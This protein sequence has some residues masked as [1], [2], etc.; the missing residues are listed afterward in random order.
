MSQTLFTE[1]KYYD[2]LSAELK[3]AKNDQQLFD[4]IV[5]LPF[6]DKKTSTMLGLGVV[7]LLLVNMKDRTIDRIALSD[8]EQAQGAVNYSVKNFKDIRI[9]LDNRDNYLGVALRT[10]RPMITSDW[11]YLFVPV[12]SP[13]EARFNQAGAGIGCSVVYPLIGAR[14]GGAMIYSFYEPIGRIGRDHHIFMEKYSQ[15]VT[16]SL[17]SL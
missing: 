14:Q 9:P 11:Q 12:L 5:N 8:T 15:L 10:K 1:K 13:Q 17:K 3:Q 2:E 6:K 16:S 4:L 7:V